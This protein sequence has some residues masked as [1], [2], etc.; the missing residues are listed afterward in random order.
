MH[1]PVSPIAA[2]V[3]VELWG[4][5]DLALRMHVL[6]PLQ[7]QNNFGRG[8]CAPISHHKRRL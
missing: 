5:I 1:L 7:Q 6:K 3:H 4:L 8:V 2:V